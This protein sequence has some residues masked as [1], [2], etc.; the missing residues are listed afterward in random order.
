MRTH[1]REPRPAQLARV[2]EEE[3]EDPWLSRTRL[4]G[5]TRARQKFNERTLK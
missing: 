5:A 4:L 3:G 1:A 2:R